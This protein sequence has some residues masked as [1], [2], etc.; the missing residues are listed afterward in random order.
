MGH[1]AREEFEEL[2]GE[3]MD[4]LP[5]ELAARVSNV[6]VVVQDLPGTEAAEARVGPSSVLLGLYTGIPLTRRGTGYWGALPDRI[7]IYQGNIEAVAGSPD[8]IR[9]TVR[10]TVIHELAHH[11]GISDE[12]LDELGW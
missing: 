2:V 11:F 9:D 12:R 6:Q 8:A 7:T 10:R 4:E 1:L 5:P 3:A